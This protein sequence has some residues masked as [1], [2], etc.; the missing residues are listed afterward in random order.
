M[1][2]R[3]FISK[4]LGYGSNQAEVT[5]T[6]TT[7]IANMLRPYSFSPQSLS[8]QYIVPRYPFPI[9]SLYQ[10]SYQSDVL[11]T[12]QRALKSEIF[13]NGHDLVPG[14]EVDE[15][16]TSSEEDID[17]KGN[18][19]KLKRDFLKWFEKCN[20]NGQSV[21]DVAKE[22]EDDLNIL[23]DCFGLF[24]MEYEFNEGGEIVSYDTKEFIRTYPGEMGM[25]INRQDRPGFNDA[26]KELLVCPVHRSDLLTEEYKCPQCGLKTYRAHYKNQTATGTVFYFENEVWHASKYRP[27]KRC[28]FSPVVTVW[29]KAF[30]LF[31]EDQYIKELYEGKRPPKGLLIFNT[32][33]IESL[34]KAWNS[35]IDEAKENPHIP[36]KIGVQSNALTGNGGSV[37]QF[38]DFMKSLDEMQFTE[39]REELRRTIGAVYGVMP[40]YQADLS[41]AGGLNNEGLQVTVTNR[42]AEDGQSIYN[43]GLFPR[44][45]KNKNMSGWVLTLRPSEE[46]DEMA[47]LTRQ[48]LAL[49]N[50]RAAADMGLSV[51]WNADTNEPI[52][53][54][55]EIKVNSSITL[56]SS[57]EISQPDDGVSSSNNMQGAPEKPDAGTDM[58]PKKP[59]IGKS[60]QSPSKTCEQCGKHFSTPGNICQYCLTGT[61]RPK[62]RLMDLTRTKKEDVA[63]AQ[64]KS[65][66]A[67]IKE[68]QNEFYK[69]LKTEIDGFLKTYKRK[70]T[71]KEIQ[72]LVDKIGKKLPDAMKRATEKQFKKIYNGA[73]E[74]VEKDLN[75]NIVRD[76][77]DV[78]MLNKLANQPVLYDAYAGVTNTIT[79]NINKIINETYDN[80]KEFTIQK[81]TEKIKETSNLAKYRAENIARTETGKVAMAARRISY[82]KEEN[83]DK[84]FLFKHIGIN[85]HRTTKTCQRIK[86]RTAKGVKWDEY[87]KIV[88]EESKKDFPDWTVDKEFPVAHY[89]CRH[90]VVRLV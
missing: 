5:N 77:R 55:G 45:L 78:V 57:G 65:P 48:Q 81:L 41:N 19:N 61:E 86:D 38:I 16:V 2:F 88:E 70:P 13:R 79:N 69:I 66:T 82:Q 50:A 47:K 8:D 75:R 33:N 21:I 53:S 36:A 28:G 89:M 22:L 15:T 51:K 4:V 59:E 12:C 43:K 62:S 11:T 20:E 56:P 37:A 35:M 25:V 85:D 14:K 67:F 18:E 24:I 3:N 23:D 26:G 58:K 52:I 73:V 87:V 17:I 64:K 9:W 10:V 34:H 72:G 27:T 7:T 71:E 44:I 83:P 40:I 6:P 31:A 30:T 1:G 46:Q 84:P 42:A 39:Y 29:M 90:S 80:P 54:E 49:Q 74:S 68:E 76:E 60:F 63:K 32:S